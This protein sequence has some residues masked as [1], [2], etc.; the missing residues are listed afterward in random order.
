V[1]ERERE[2][3]RRFENQFLQVFSARVGLEPA[4]PDKEGKRAKRITIRDGNSIARSQSSQLDLSD[5]MHGYMTGQ[6]TLCLT[7]AER[8]LRINS[9][10][11]FRPGGER[12]VI[13]GPD[14]VS[15]LRILRD[16]YIHIPM[17]IIKRHLAF[18]LIHTTAST[19]NNIS[20][21]WGGGHRLTVWLVTCGVGFYMY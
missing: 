11:F 14:G 21:Q 13:N 1:R 6:W 3:E 17:N 8:D 20:L 10:K 19:E 18:R 15:L 9:Y 12:N 7:L 16:W 4:T 5:T 2:R